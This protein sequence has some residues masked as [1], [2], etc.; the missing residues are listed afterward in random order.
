[1]K[2]NNLKTKTLEY[3]RWC[4]MKAR[5]YAPSCKN[6]GRYQK[7]GI[8]VCD[9]W[10]HSF[11][12]FLEDMGR[13][14]AP[15]YS[16]ERINIEGDYCPE[17]CRWIPKNEQSKNTSKNKWFTYKGKTQILSDWANELGLHYDT[18]HHRVTDGGM[19]FEE[20]IKLGNTPK[21]Y[22]TI[23]GKSQYISDWCKEKGL[24]LSAVY[25]YISRHN[26]SAK[27]AL[28]HYIKLKEG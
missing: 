15:N 6:T 26:I 21:K 19:S 3:K 14:P 7:L 9:R 11:E 25:T 28:L 16:V 22:I 18:L 24:S 4:S 13:M 20:A 1:M 10:L 23:D 27:D 12:N 5:C 8:K 17:N 2:K